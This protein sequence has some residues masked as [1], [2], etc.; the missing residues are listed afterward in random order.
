M[1][2]QKNARLLA[3]TITGYPSCSILISP[4]VVVGMLIAGGVDAA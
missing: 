3:A 1:I 2:K 4:V